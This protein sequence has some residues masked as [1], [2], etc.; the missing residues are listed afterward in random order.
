MKR[1]ALEKTNQRLPEWLELGR[2][3]S[4]SGASA[5][6]FPGAIICPWPRPFPFHPGRVEVAWSFGRS[7]D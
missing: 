6:P 1:E 7:L 4:M 2:S 5:F 3:K